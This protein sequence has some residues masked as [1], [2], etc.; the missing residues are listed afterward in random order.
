MQLAFRFLDQSGEGDYEITRVLPPAIDGEMQYRVRGADGH[1]R[2]VGE[3]QMRKK[4]AA[5]DVLS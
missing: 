5:V 3:L 2:A 4:D 1:E